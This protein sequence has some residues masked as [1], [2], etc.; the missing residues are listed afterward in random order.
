MK[1]IIS[2]LLCLTLLFCLSVSAFADEDVADSS[3]ELVISSA[4]EFLAFAENCRLDSFSQN[5]NVILEKDIDLSGCEFESI[6]IFCGSFDGKGHSISGLKVDGYGSV[7]GLFRYVAA[8][9]EIRNLKVSGDIQPEGSHNQVGGIA[10]SNSG[11]IIGCS[12][13]GSLSGSEQVG[14]LAGINTVSGIIDSCSVNGELF[15]DHFVGGIAGENNGVIRNCVNSAEVNTSARQNSVELEDISMESMTGSESANTVTDVGGIAGISNGVIRA[16][17]NYGNVGYQ[18][19]GY[20]IGGIAGTQSGYIA[21]CKNYVQILGRK[22]VGGIVGQMEPASVMEYSQDALQILE[23]QLGTMSDLVNQA[24]YNAQSNASYI[25]GN[26]AALQDQTY[27]AVDILDVLFSEGTF[28]P[29]SIVAAQNALS[30]TFTEMSQTMGRISSATQ[31]T[32]HGLSSDLQAISGQI[33]AMGQTLED[34]SETLGGSFVDVSDEDTPDILIGKIDNCMNYGDILADTNVGGIVGALSVENDLDILEDWQQSGEL[35]L[36]FEGEIRAV[37]LNCDN[38][39][40]VTGKKQNAGGIAGLQDIGLVK[41]CSNSGV[42]DAASA[43]YVGG[44]SGRSQGFIRN[45]Y[46]KSEIHGSSYVGGIAGSASIATDCLTMSTIHDSIEKIGAVLGITESSNNDA[47]AP[48]AS[49]FY[50]RTD[51]DIGAI[52][53]ISYSGLAEPLNLEQFLSIDDLPQ[54]F[55]NVLVR[56]FFEDGTEKRFYLKPGDSLEPSD[57][58]SI[59]EKVG[60]SSFWA[61]NDIEALSSVVHNISFTAQYIANSSVI[62]SEEDRDGMPLLLALGEFTE[63][64]RLS[65]FPASDLPALP[66]YEDLVECWEFEVSGTAELDSFHFK[67]PAELEVYKLYVGSDDG[68]WRET[69]FKVDGSYIVFDAESSDRYIAISQMESFN[70]LT[71]L[72]LAAVLILM[73]II[74]KKLYRRRKNKC[75]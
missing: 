6:P 73:L 56:F 63:N 44:I 75:G 38:H 40:K 12:F 9:A 37:V 58:P 11:S 16:C 35:S 23:Q 1:K 74:A 57:M 20:N 45:N 7:Q 64:N 61:G 53:G 70:W 39:G 50:L 31:N 43:D 10:G 49:N 65:I 14:G 13:S 15:G 68:Q 33:N 60:H 18:H 46:S 69:E 2:L 66:D 19:M 3:R 51:S 67:I 34:A 8:G 59:P 54:L 17:S 22:E 21:D 30:S 4:E 41:G 24:S 27:S 55:D 42:I 28:D 29:D 62:E 5:L 26:L 48:F 25:T 32:I 72:V 47:E 36:N 71:C 52:D